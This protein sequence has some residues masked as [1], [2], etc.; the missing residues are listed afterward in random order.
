MAANAA[1]PPA[2]PARASGPRAA[3]DL[4]G[5][6]PPAVRS[7]RSRTQGRPAGLGKGAFGLVD[8]MERSALRSRERRFESCWGRCVISQDMGDAPN[9]HWVQGDMNSGRVVFR[10][11]GS[12]GWGR[13]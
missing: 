6:L 4:D 7:G 12:P 8:G 2:R 10:W 9:L 5:Y 3:S 11:A 13:G 1:S